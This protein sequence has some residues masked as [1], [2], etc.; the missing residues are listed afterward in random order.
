[1]RDALTPAEWRTLA[2]I[3]LVIFGAWVLYR[4]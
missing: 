1:V 4:W 2:V 3:L